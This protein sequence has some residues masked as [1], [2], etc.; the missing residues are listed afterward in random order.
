MGKPLV[1][2][3]DLTE[4]PPEVSAAGP[5]SMLPGRRRPT[6]RAVIEALHTA[7]RDPDVAGLIARVGG[8][9]P[10]ARAQELRDAVREF[11]RTKRAVAYAETFGEGSPGTVPYLLATGF[12]EIWLQPS[13]DLGLT[14]IAA[15]STFLRGVLD[16]VGL[17]PQIS[18]RHEYKNA[19]DRLTRHGYTDAF[20]EASGRLVESAYEQVVA[21]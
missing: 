14:G 15:E 3:L 2:E 5:L 20:R 12:S 1:L 4:A 6:L 21:G 10:L 19:V 17:E 8:G 9:L 18:Q 11:A 13:G 16:K 7:A